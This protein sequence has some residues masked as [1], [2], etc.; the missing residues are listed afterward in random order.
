MKIS[1]S[2]RAIALCSLL[3]SC[4]A[5]SLISPG[6]AFGNTSALQ[7]CVNKQTLVLRV[8]SKCTKDETKIRWNVTSPIGLSGDKE[9][10]ESLL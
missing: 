9:D 6:S 2:T 8:S 1:I 7:G 5:S 3:V 4:L 10:Y